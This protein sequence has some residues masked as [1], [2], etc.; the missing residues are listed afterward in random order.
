MKK[1][2]PVFCL[3]I[4]TLLTSCDK[5]KNPAVVKTT[6]VGSNFITK[7]N[8]AISNFKKV[9]LED[10]TGHKCGNC[11]PAAVLAETLENK[12]HDTLV[13]IAVH[14][15]DFAKVRLPDHP[16]SYTTTAGYD[17]DS[18]AGGGFAVSFPAGNPNGMVNRTAYPGFNKVHKD[19]W[20]TTVALGK[21][22]PF[23]VKLD[24]TTNYDPTVRALNTD[25][26]AT[27]KTTY[28]V[29]TK[30]S[31]VL[32]EDSIIGAQTDYRF[33]PDLITAYKFNSVLRGALNGSWGDVLKST[34][35]AVNDSVKVSFPNFALN[36]SFNDKKI[37]VVVFVY[38]E[39]TKEVLQVEKLKIR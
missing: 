37:S 28:T 11:P 38:N 7:S 32:I 8:S 3:A 22:D 26:K 31:V 12:Y 13:V 1:I 14:A 35:A 25:V 18:N 10:Y 34:A 36:S 20:A 19:T 4:L 16:D 6:A 23:V 17:W 9:L 5:V 2:I 33:N 15:G 39:T 27:F 24:I 21:K 29:N 30:I